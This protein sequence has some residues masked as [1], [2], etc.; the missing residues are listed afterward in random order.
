MPEQL[1]GGVAN[2]GMVIRDGDIVSR[3]APSNV[4][5]IHRLL[6]HVVSKGFPA[7]E[8]LD[9]GQDGQEALRYIPGE[10]SVPPYSE[11]WI[12]SEATLIEVGRFLRSY[13]EAVEGFAPAADAEWSVE[14]ADPSSG[15]LICHNDVCIE[16]VVFQGGRT[17]GLLDFDFAAPGR[18]LWDLVMTARYWVPL[19]DP[20]SADATGRGDLDVLARVRILADA[21]ELDEADRRSF[22]SVLMEIEAVALDF[23]LGRIERG[24]PAFA[25]MWDE[26][27]GETRYLRKMAW[28]EGQLPRIESALSE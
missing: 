28:L 26:L 9:P 20:I 15:T 14:L 4:S 24:E 23:V 12:R 22:G 21:Y 7:P 11:P 3:P 2:A 27:G 18:P 6:N 13:H 8:P 19:L 1:E 5:T 16:N 17:V 25:R 10:V